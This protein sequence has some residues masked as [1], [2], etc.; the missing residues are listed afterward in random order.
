MMPTFCQTVPRPMWPKKLRFLPSTRRLQA[1]EVL[2]GRSSDDA[3]VWTV[4]GS[5]RARQ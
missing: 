3:V 2:Q 4:A 5:H 1:F